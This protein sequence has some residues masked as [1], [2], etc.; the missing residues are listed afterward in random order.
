MALPS[1]L[2]EENRLKTS[3][4]VWPSRKRD[5]PPLAPPRPTQ[6][7]STSLDGAAHASWRRWCRRNFTGEISP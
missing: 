2:I 4:F 7:V 3:S 1:Y 6:R 5:K